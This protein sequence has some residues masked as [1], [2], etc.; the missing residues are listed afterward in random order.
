MGEL[1]ARLRQTRLYD[2]ARKTWW[3]KKPLLAIYEA[4]YR[5]YWFVARILIRCRSALELLF[6]L[7]GRAKHS[8]KIDEHL[9]AMLVI[10]NVAI[11]PRVEREARALSS[12]G[13][14][15]LIVAPDFDNPAPDWGPNIFFRFCPLMAAIEINQFPWVF[16]GRMLRMARGVAPFVY[17]C[18]DLWTVLMGAAAARE[19]GSKL[20]VDFHEWFSENVSDRM[21]PHSGLKKLVYRRLEKFA[22]RRADIVITVCKSIADEL[23]KM[24]NRDIEILRNIPPLELGSRVYP[25]I[26]RQLDI[27]DDSFVILYQGGVGPTR[28]LP[29]IIKALEHMPDVA[30]VIRGPGIEFFGPEYRA[31]ATSVGAESRLYLAPTVPSPDVIAAANGADAGIW[32]L[33]PICKNFYYALP[34]KVF[35]YLAAGLP[36]LVADLPEVRREILDRGL[37]EGFGPS[38]PKSIASAV[39]RLRNDVLIGSRVKSMKF[40]PDWARLVG[41]YDRLS[42]GV[43]EGEIVACEQG[44]RR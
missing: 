20:V 21:R 44:L 27:P 11:D 7:S 3:L 18:H 5:G 33:D 9:I 26:R 10:S 39:Q 15:V 32:S 42:R 31:I 30:L 14:R 28:N 40:E 12:A 17:H 38:D 6:M 25:T 35:E 19:H 13:Y 23:K 29:P 36:L 34:N 22:L 24:H 43:A 2:F 37:G 4:T 8:K 1:L 41:F 16:S